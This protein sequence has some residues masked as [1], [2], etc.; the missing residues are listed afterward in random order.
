MH[1]PLEVLGAMITPAVLISAAALL[2][3]STAA[4]LGRV[5][6]RLLHLIAEAEKLSVQPTDRRKIDDERRL[7]S[8]QMSSLKDRLVLLRSSMSALYM[9]IG[10]LVLTSLAGGVYVLIPSVTSIFPIS[11][12]MLG[13]V[14]FLYGIVLLTREAAAAEHVTL[15]E[16]DY[17]CEL[18]QTTADE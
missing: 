9:T 16:I 1:Q 17:A 13:A 8:Q 18:L 2:L 5:N 11:I 3:L 14:A 12:G 7:L 15:Q 4:R 10:L 6:D